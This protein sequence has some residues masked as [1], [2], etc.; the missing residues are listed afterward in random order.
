MNKQTGFTLIELAIVLVIIG[1]LLGG[2]LRGQE[3]INSARVKSLIRDFQNTQVFLYGYQDRFRALPGDD[4]GVLGRGFPA[5]VAAGPAGTIGNG[6]INGAWNSV[7]ATDESNLFWQH[8][9]MAGFAPGTIVPGAGIL[10]TN[11]NGGPIGIE[12]IG[13]GFAQIVDAVPFTGSFA[14]CTT[15][16][17]GRDVIDL[18]TQLDDGNT[19]AGILRANIVA[20]PS[21]PTAAVAGAPAVAHT[22]CMAI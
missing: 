21:L 11:A 4:A 19:A 14:I 12:S 18:D 17:L 1:L 5:G 15:G 16:I 8:V 13:D 2:V 9:R 22:V 3:L 10:P 7:T 6:Q 20:G